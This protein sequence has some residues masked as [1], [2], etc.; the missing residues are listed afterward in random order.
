VGERYA[1]RNILDVHASINL[2][3]VINK[4]TRIL[5]EVGALTAL[6]DADFHGGLA[7]AAKQHR[8]WL[9]EFIHS[10]CSTTV[11]QTLEAH[12]DNHE[13]DSVVAIF[14]LLQEYSGATRESIM[15][16]EAHLHPNKLVREQV[17]TIMGSGGRVSDTLFI[18]LHT[19]LS[20]S[21]TKSAFTGDRNNA[22]LGISVP[23]VQ[24]LEWAKKWRKHH[25]EG[26]A[27]SVMQFLANV[28]MEFERVKQLDQ[29]KITDPNSNI[30]ALQAQ[31]RDMELML[32][33]FH[34]CEQKTLQTPAN[35]TTNLRNNL[36]ST[37]KQVNGPQ[38]HPAPNAT[39]TALQTLHNGR[40]WKYCHRCGLDGRWNTTHTTAEHTGVSRTPV[41]TYNVGHYD[42]HT[43]AATDTADQ[44]DSD[45]IHANYAAAVGGGILDF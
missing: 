7:L 24:I 10:F 17:R 29:W 25:G 14:W 1:F 9:G 30:I 43:C 23:C 18:N 11:R 13:N 33:T 4:R 35:S 20:E 37:C 21:H 32:K 22:K 31:L 40:T 41:P 19:A 38:W 34:A 36:F 6:P 16:A 2:K 45:S 3:M 8:N 15:L 5:R 26:A 44:A 28:G 12:Q 27:W 42:A 39:G